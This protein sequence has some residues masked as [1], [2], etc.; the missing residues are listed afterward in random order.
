MLTEQDHSETKT[1]IDVLA[2]LK[3]GE[4]GWIVKVLDLIEFTASTMLVL[5]FTKDGKPKTKMQLL[6][7]IPGIIRFA[8]EFMRRLNGERGKM[9]QAQLDQK[10]ADSVDKSIAANKQINAAKKRWE[11]NDPDK[12]TFEGNL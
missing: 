6:L 7:S 9:S 12:I 3:T 11:K 1:S 2:H 5:M 8:K 10:A 4:P